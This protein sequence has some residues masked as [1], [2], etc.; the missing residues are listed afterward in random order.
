L[1]TSAPMAMALVFVKISI[2]DFVSRFHWQNLFNHFYA[3]EV[4]S[5]PKI[6]KLTKIRLWEMSGFT[7]YHFRIWKWGQKK[8]NE[9]FISILK[10]PQSK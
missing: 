3:T 4:H 8:S 10:I 7:V 6:M 5:C 2:E 1:V 9:K